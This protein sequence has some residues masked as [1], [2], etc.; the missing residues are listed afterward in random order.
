MRHWKMIHMDYIWT[1][2]GLCLF[3]W[4]HGDMDLLRNAARGGSVACVL[5][6]CASVLSNV[7]YEKEDLYEAGGCMKICIRTRVMHLRSVEHTCMHMRDYKY[8]GLRPWR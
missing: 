2:F 1:L 5:G 3:V 6:S 8:T 7:L 4:A